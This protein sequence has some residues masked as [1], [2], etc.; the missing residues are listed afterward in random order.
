MTFIHISKV[1]EKHGERSLEIKGRLGKG[2]VGERVRRGTAPSSSPLLS[3]PLLSP[4]SHK[5]RKSY[6]YEG[7][8]ERRER[9]R[10]EDGG[11]RG[12]WGKRRMGDSGDRKL[13]HGEGKVER[14]ISLTISK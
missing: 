4:L 5:E 11:E 3:L 1:E 2:S 6:R 10:R 9:G 12:G 14:G 13:E 8:E 7:E